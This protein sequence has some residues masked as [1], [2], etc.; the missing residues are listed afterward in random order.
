MCITCINSNLSQLLKRLTND[1]QL[2]CP[3]NN[4]VMSNINTRL[5]WAFL[6]VMSFCVLFLIRQLDSFYVSSVRF[7]IIMIIIIINKYQYK[8]DFA[9]KWLGQ[10]FLARRHQQNLVQLL[11]G[12][13]NVGQRHPVLGLSVSACVRL[14]THLKSLLR[15]LPNSQFV[16]GDKDELIEFWGQKFKDHN[17]TVVKYQLVNTMF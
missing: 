14:L 2:K 13:I 16:V 10:L 17:E 6:R 1:S 12:F 8:F 7:L 11:A 9:S 15:T 4:H 3:I 5:L